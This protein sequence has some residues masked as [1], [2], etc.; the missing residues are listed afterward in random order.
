MVIIIVCSDIDYH[1]RFLV[2][3][4][5]SFYGTDSIDLLL[6]LGASSFSYRLGTEYLLILSGPATNKQRD[7]RR[8]LFDSIRFAEQSRVENQ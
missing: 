8:L 3:I 1:S 7:K 2:L 5:C 4:C 6:R